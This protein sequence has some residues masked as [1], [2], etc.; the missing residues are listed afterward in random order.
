MS[1]PKI[2]E[3]SL[4][5]GPACAMTIARK[6]LWVSLSHFLYYEERRPKRLYTRRLCIACENIHKQGLTQSMVTFSHKTFGVLALS[7][8]KFMG[9]IF[10]TPSILHNYTIYQRTGGVVLYVVIWRCQIKTIYTRYFV[11]CFGHSRDRFIRTK[12]DFWGPFH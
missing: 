1:V 3:E 7:I 2:M 9:E 5:V 10:R 11:S 12:G 4:E 8:S 6:P